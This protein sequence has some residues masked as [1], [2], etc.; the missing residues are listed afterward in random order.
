MSTVK[1]GNFL[2]LIWNFYYIDDCSL[3]SSIVQNNHFPKSEGC[4]MLRGKR[5]DR[6]LLSGTVLLLI[7]FLAGCAAKKPLWGDL[8]SGLL[9]RYQASAD[10]ALRY[11]TASNAKQVMKFNDQPMETQIRSGLV[12]SALPKAAGQGLLSVQ[13][14]LDSAGTSITSAMGDMA[15]D[16]GPILGK[17]FTMTL[18]ELGKELDLAGASALKYDL[19]PMGQRDL[20]SEFQNLFEDLPAAP[21]KAGQSW[22]T[23]DTTLVDQGGMNVKVITENLNTFEG[24][25]TVGGL[26]CV[27]VRVESKGGMDGSGEQ[28]GAQIAMTGKIDSKGVWFFAYKKGVLVRSIGDTRN[29][30]TITVSGQQNMTMPMSMTVHV[31]RNLL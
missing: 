29:E 24:L 12:F 14:G 3:K 5:L 31:E 21:V 28:M 30:S 8:K 25:E 4:A 20:K 26:E 19:G 1:G 2:A 13:I 23:H 6:T 18:S 10:K 9:L 27:R 16:F 15:P 17:G 7:V 11:R 22:T